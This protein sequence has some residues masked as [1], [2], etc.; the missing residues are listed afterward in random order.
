MKH[1][2]TFIATKRSGTSNVCGESYAE[3]SSTLFECYF[4][5]VGFEFLT[6]VVMKGV[7]S[8][9]T[10]PYSSY[11]NQR[12]G[13]T[14]TSIFR[15]E[16]H[17]RVLNRFKL[18]AAGSLFPELEHSYCRSLTTYEYYIGRSG[19]RLRPLATN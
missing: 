11:M 9:H 3:F 15:V 17:V 13:G 10:A 7:I 18:R 8:R 19:R 14:I 12:L 2:E 1:Y 16:N 5:L 6:A 4:F